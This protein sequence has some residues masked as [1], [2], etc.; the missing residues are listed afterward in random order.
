VGAT[1]RL[2]RL[3]AVSPHRADR[4]SAAQA[5]RIA[6]IAARRHGINDPIEPL[7]T[8]DNHVLRAGDVVVRVAPRSADVSSQI[9]LAR[10]LIAEG[11]GV[12]APLA[13]AETIDG[14]QLSLWEYVDADARRPID[15][16]QLGEIVA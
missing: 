16:E 3:D 6:A 2:G 5:T 8:G 12:P 1:C 14:A 9:A 13:D 10:W 7:R 4:V 11:F 15:F